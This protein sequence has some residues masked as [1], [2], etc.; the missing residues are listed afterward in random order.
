MLGTKRFSVAGFTTLALLTTLAGPMAQ[1]DVPY[2]VSYSPEESVCISTSGQEI[3][4][5]WCSGPLPAQD[6]PR[7]S[8]DETNGLCITA[9][10][11]TACTGPVSGRE[12]PGVQYTNEQGLCVSALLAGTVCTGPLP[13]VEGSLLGSP[14]VPATPELDISM[15]QLE[16]AARL[17]WPDTFAG[18]WADETDQNIITAI[19]IAFTANAPE[20]VDRLASTFMEPSLLKAKTFDRSLTELE[21]RQRQMIEDRELAKTGDLVLPGV[22]GGNYDL[23]IDLLRNAV[24]VIVEEVSELARQTFET[25]YGEDVIVQ[26]GDLAVP[27]CTRGDCRYS[28]RSGLA[29]GIPNNTPC[30]TAFTVVRPNGTR[31][32]LSAGHCAPA[33]WS[34][35]VGTLRT[36]GGPQYG[37]VQAEQQFHRVDAER[38]SVNSPYDAKAWIYVDHNNK[39]VSVLDRSS[40]EGLMKGLD[41]CKS[42]IATDKSCGPIDGKNYSPTYIPNAE[43]FVRLNACSNYGDSGAGVY[44]ESNPS[45][46]HGILSGGGPPFSCPDSRDY[47]LFG[48]IEYALSALGVTLAAGS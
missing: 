19:W 31:N 27:Q 41:A 20:N 37:N 14:G 33:G 45:R 13:A 28:L 17:A 12:L 23:D 9:E 46:V 3:P 21:N 10:T 7:V 43:R 18:I 38:H 34:N 44:R 15:E 25:L 24:V 6:L 35:D 5:R 16:P 42:G 1:A 36:H 8:Y 2:K 26:E 30:S 47:F 39:S 4:Q 40:W 29:T 11:K 32:I 48:H 22:P